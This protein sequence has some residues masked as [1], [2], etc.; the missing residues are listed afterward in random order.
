MSEPS[1]RD[2]SLNSHGIYVASSW[3]NLHQP[4]IVG[5]LREQGH[6][7]YDF[8]HPH[9]GDDGFSWHEVDPNWKSWDTRKFR[10]ALSH[11][12]AER[13]YQYDIDA[14]D[15]SEVVVLLLPSGKSAHVEAGYA[16]GRG[17]VVIVHSPGPEYVEPELMYKMFNAITTLGDNELAVMLDRPLAQLEMLTLAATT[18]WATFK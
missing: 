8:R 12:L 17:R 10:G 9:T 15:T 6:L 16:A 13:G 3:R 1:I 5:L 18:A 2:Q 4:R 7:V 14:L 11:P